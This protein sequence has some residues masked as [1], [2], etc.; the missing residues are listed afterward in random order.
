MKHYTLHHFPF[1]RA[2]PRSARAT[3]CCQ[4]REGHTGAP[5]HLLWE[6]EAMPLDAA[7]LWEVLQWSGCVLAAASLLPAVLLLCARCA[8]R[9]PTPPP[10]G[11]ELGP[12]AVQP[13]AP[14]APELQN[15]SRSP[16]PQSQN[17]TEVQ[18]APKSS[19]RLGDVSRRQ[20]PRIP[21]QEGKEIRR[22]SSYTG[23]Y[24]VAN[25]LRCHWPELDGR[26]TSTCSRPHEEE[27]FP[28]YAQVHK[29]RPASQTD[30]DSTD[31]HL[32]AKVKKAGGRSVQSEL[33]F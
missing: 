9:K 12:Q 14:A 7:H 22:H 17:P 23:E 13:S 6:T 29:T 33:I 2:H 21:L 8:K 15:N 30:R 28:V 4:R 19:E 26:N 31:L 27:P 16:E 24:T 10:A 18:Q 5:L 1:I 3:D 32:Y 20:L 11:L 25:E